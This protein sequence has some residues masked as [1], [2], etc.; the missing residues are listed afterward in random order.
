MSLCD[1]LEEGIVV[2]VLVDASKVQ[3]VCLFR[4]R[5][6]AGGFFVGVVFEN[7]FAVYEGAQVVS[8]GTGDGRGWGIRT[9]DLDLLRG[10][11][12]PEMRKTEDS[13]VVLFLWSKLDQRVYLPSNKDKYAPSIP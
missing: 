1:T 10:G 7:F 2:R 9:G 3:R 13:V 4:R 5:R 11:L 8:D 6:S 12:V